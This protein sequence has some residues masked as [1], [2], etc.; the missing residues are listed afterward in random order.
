[1]NVRRYFVPLCFGIFGMLLGCSPSDQATSDTAADETGRPNILFIVGDDLGFTD[2][3]SFGGEISTPNLDRLAYQ[4]LRFTNLHAASACRSARLMLMASASSAAASQPI[5][6][7]FRGAALG[8]FRYA[9]G[10]S[11]PEVGGHARRRH[12]HD[13]GR[14]RRQA[15]R[16][17]RARRACSRA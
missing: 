13:R 3:G 4:G 8:L 7:A 1:M 14:R 10:P 5:S 15:Q 12:A 17:A 11:E 2:L 6:E 9:G 16:P